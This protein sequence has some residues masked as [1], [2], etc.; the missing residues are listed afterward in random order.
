MVPHGDDFTYSLLIPAN[1]WT[2]RIVAAESYRV[3]HE[4]LRAVLSEARI[5]AEIVSMDESKVSQAC[6]ENPVRYDILVAGRKAAGAA[7]R[8]SRLGLMHQGSVQGLS[9]PPDF[10]V[11]FAGHLAAEVRSNHYDTR[12]TAGNV[13]AEKYATPVWLKMR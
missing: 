4:A 3:I 1:A 12:Q 2:A 11:R 5:A 9:L 10:G 6:F 7:Q 13:A 8:R